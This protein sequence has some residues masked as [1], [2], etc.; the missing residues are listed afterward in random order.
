MLPCLPT[1]LSADIDMNP[2]F[3]AAVVVT[4]LVVVFLALLILIFFVMGYGGIFQAINKS[5]EKKAKAQQKSEVNAEIPAASAPAPTVKPQASQEFDA[6]DEVVAVIAAAVAQISAEN[7]KTAVIKSIKPAKSRP[8]RLAWAK[9][10]LIDN[11][12]PF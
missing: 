2:E 1:I 8:S 12:R 4:G 5:R 3:V 9:A 11:T 10:G 7:G 6:E